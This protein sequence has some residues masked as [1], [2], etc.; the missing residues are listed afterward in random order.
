MLYL[1]H[2]WNDELLRSHFVNILSP[3]S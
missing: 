3:Y 1:I 2:L